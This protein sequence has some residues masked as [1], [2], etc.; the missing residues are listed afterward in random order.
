[1]AMHQGKRR[2]QL[3]LGWSTG[4]DKRL[5]QAI[6]FTCSYILYLRCE[7]AILVTL[8]VCLPISTT[9]GAGSGAELLKSLVLCNDILWLMDR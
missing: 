1:M 7:A 8:C 4:R 3:N 2:R 5:V 9:T 6:S